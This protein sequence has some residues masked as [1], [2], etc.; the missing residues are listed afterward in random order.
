MEVVESCGI[1]A[2]CAACVGLELYRYCVQ[3][4][5]GSAEQDAIQNKNSIHVRP[6]SAKCLWCVHSDRGSEQSLTSQ[7][8]IPAK[9]ED[10][11]RSFRRYKLSLDEIVVTG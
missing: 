2:A 10:E 3:M 5:L 7:E 6:L 4:V 11:K 8:M 1:Y 9:A